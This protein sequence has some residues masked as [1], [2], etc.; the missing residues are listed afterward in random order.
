M[1]VLAGVIVLAGWAV[2]AAH[3][4]TQTTTRLVTFAARSCPAYTDV[5][6]NR[7]RNNIMESLEDLGQDS[8]YDGV[9][10][11]SP[12][13]EEPQ[14][15]TCSPLPDWRFTLGKGIRTGV[16]GPWGSLSV[17]TSPFDTSI[18]TKDSTPLLDR[19]GS[20]TGEN[21]AGAVTIRLSDAEINQISSGQLWAQGGTPTD[22]VLRDLYPG[23]GLPPTYGY[24]ALRCAL[25]ALNGDNVEYISYPSGAKHVFCYAYYV[26]PPPTSGTIIVKK[27]VDDPDATSGTAFTFQGDISYTSD[28]KFGLTASYGKPASE[29]FFR[30]GGQTWSWK[31]L[32]LS[33]WTMVG[34]SCTLGQ[35]R[36]STTNTDVATGSVS[37]DLAAGTRSRA[38]TPTGPMPPPVGL[39]L[40]RRTRAAWGASA[41]TS[42]ARSRRARR[43]RRPAAHGDA[44]RPAVAGPPGTYGV[45]ERPPAPAPAGRWS[46]AHVTATGSV[47][48]STGDASRSCPGGARHVSSPTSFTPGGSI[49][50]RKRTEGAA[51]S[52]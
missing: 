39:L 45:T 2:P 46:L 42:T 31:E 24:A 47:R 33:G 15:T 9:N 23:P 21:L 52:A 22:P 19:N 35:G 20:R 44:G 28:Q 25:D 14:H 43:S 37:V 38:P 34:L 30:A 40:S 41:S 7:A 32:P 16:T 10:P 49:M 13:V 8:T 4:G 11:V 18:V 5:T 36:A 27:V 51:G 29:T 6:A 3:A 48:R 17:D 26:V 50:L 1:C 12:V